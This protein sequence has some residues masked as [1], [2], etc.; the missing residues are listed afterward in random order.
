MTR[1]QAYAQ[2]VVAMG[3]M[4]A[5]QMLLGDS[6]FTTGPSGD[7]QQGS[8]LALSMVTQYGMGER[9]LVKSDGVMSVSA[10]ASDEA[11]EEADALLRR[12]LVDAGALLEAN[13]GMFDRLVAALLEFETLT[14]AQIDELVAGHELTVTSTPPPSPRRNPSSIRIPRQ[15][16]PVVL[17]TPLAQTVPVMQRIRSMPA[18]ANFM[19]RKRKA[20]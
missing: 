8:N 19:R 15:T 9:L 13:R 6:E 12:A 16:P 3:G 10:G 5:E 7:L 4:A 20:S 18:V 17:P 1:R 11:V 14:H 2:L